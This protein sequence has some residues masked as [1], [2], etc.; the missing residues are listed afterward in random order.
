M[1]FIWF[2]TEVRTRL[3]LRNSSTAG[4]RRS[5]FA[6]FL[7]V[8]LSENDFPVEKNVVRVES[9]SANNFMRLNFM[10]K[11]FKLLWRSVPVFVSSFCLSRKSS[12]LSS[13]SCEINKFNTC[14]A[15]QEAENKTGYEINAACLNKPRQYAGSVKLR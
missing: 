2:K 9:F 6:R 7:I 12:I 15:Y 1:L 5:A 14:I 8:N 3:T 13:L 11:S 4:I 10:Q